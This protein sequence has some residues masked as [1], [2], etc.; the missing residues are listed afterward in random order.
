MKSIKSILERSPLEICKALWVRTSPLWKNKIYLKVLYYLNHGYGLNLKSPQKFTEKLQW[1]KL[2]DR[3]PE[4][5]KLVDKA[6]VKNIIGEKIGFEHIIPT[7]RE[8]N[9]VEEIE[10]EKLPEQ[11]V[12]KTT[13]TGGGGG[14]VICK[15]KNKFDK[16]KAIIKLTKSL[17]SD[18][19]MGHREMP[20]KYVPRK[21]IVEPYIE[22]PTNH[23]L[24]D[25]KIFCF[26]GEPK[27]FKVDFGRFIE[28]HA[29]YYDLDWNILPYGESG[30]E[31]DFLHKENKPRNFD[32][33]I[34]IAQEL[35]AGIPFVR[36]DLYNVSGQ[37]YFGEFTLYP[38]S[39]LLPWTDIKTDYEIGS[40]LNLP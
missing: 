2:Y 6:T 38:A 9:S 36:I 18:G 19:Y 28:H 12:L 40:F 22:D 23:E 11:F 14:V 5:S 26:N 20:Y 15:D 21:I 10:W 30:L 7:I 33:M 4:Y 35:S 3:N 32:R 1:L 31:P 39:G 37:I 8:W 16:K 29:N 17:K 13:H 24:K 34:S 27:F 25:Y